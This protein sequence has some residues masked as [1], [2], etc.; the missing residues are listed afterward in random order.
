ML[1]PIRAILHSKS[2]RGIKIIALS[3]LLVL[4]CAAPIMLY[5]YFGPEQGNPVALSWVFALGAVAA[6]IGFLVGMFL[7]I[8]DIYFAKK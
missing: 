3:L 6:H 8:W 2:P 7:L 5:S 1:N 4:V